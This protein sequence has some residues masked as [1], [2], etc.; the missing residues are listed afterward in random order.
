MLI[1]K[2]TKE[3]KRKGYSHMIN[4]LFGKCKYILVTSINK[5]K[6][7]LFMNLNFMILKF[8]NHKI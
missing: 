8:K 6:P 7:E 2:K 4:E 5:L 1:A 3:N